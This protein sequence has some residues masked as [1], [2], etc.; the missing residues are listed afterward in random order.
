MVVEKAGGDLVL[1]DVPVNKP[2]KGHI[3]VKTLACGVC[4]SDEAVRQGGFGDL[5][6]AFYCSAL[7]PSTD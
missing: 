7:D 2:E 4:H 5:L 3:L 6:Y 1:K